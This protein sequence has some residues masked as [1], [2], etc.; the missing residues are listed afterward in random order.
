MPPLATA[1]LAVLVSF[2]PTIQSAAKKPAKDPRLLFEAALEQ[3]ARSIGAGRFSR[4]R[5]TLI[6]AIAEHGDADYVL[7]TLPGIQEDLEQCAF[8]SQYTRPQAEDAVAGELV[9]CD[10]R[11]GEIK[12]RYRLDAA[13]R[14]KLA[15][16]RRGTRKLP[17]ESDFEESEEIYVHPLVFR[18]PYS[19]EI[20]CG[21]IGAHQPRVAACMQ[22]TGF[23]LFLIGSPAAI[24]RIE[25]KTRREL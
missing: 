22:P 4:A 2:L 21:P 16:Q 5:E 9:S 8:W 11:T 13:K 6:A 17:F 14:K 25:G 24:Y 3:V 10:A 1:A 23:Y 12:L 20:R 18:G 7:D 19:L 15:K